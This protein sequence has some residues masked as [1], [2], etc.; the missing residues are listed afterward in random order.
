MNLNQVTLP[1]KN[2][3]QAN[4]F[5]QKLGFNLIVESPHY[6]RFECPE[7]TSSFSLIL[8]P[9]DYQNGAVIYF[10]SEK[11]DS[12]VDEL[13]SK[14]VKFYSMPKDQSYLWREAELFDPSNNKIKLY[15]AGENRLNPPWRIN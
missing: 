3:P 9:G 12:W 11:L 6:S 7:G 1:V 15:W 4:E 14:G 8:D 2:I 13:I 10:E 5:Y